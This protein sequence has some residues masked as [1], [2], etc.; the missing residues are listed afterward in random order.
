MSSM[1]DAKEWGKQYS[2]SLGIPTTVSNIVGA[3]IAA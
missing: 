1:V 3:K 2:K